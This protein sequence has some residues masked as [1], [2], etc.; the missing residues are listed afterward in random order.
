MYMY[1]ALAITSTLIFTGCSSTGSSTQNT[2]ATKIVRQIDQS[3]VVK[4]TME[5]LHTSFT[6]SSA[7]S[8]YSGSVIELTGEVVAYGLT[9]EGLF[10][11]TIEDSDA[12]VLCTF[13]DTIAN[14]VGGGRVVSK[15]K[16]VTLQGQCFASGLFSSTPFT[17]DGCTLVSN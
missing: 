5:E 9:E 3:H 7:T 15:G 10:T 16:T 17:L 11:I 8:E 12:H 13:D 1:L 4:P 14:K 6:D 2:Q